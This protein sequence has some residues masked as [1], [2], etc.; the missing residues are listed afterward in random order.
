MLQ[1][2]LGSATMAPSSIVRHPPSCRYPTMRYEMLRLISLSP[3]ANQPL[4]NGVYLTRLAG[5]G[6][7]QSQ[8]GRMVCFDCGCQYGS[9][10]QV[11]CNKERYSISLLLC[12]EQM[13]EDRDALEG[14]RDAEANGILTLRGGVTV[15]G[16]ILGAAL[17]SSGPL[18][19]SDTRPVHP[20][21]CRP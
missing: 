7:F 18:D 14:V 13:S 12:L 1:V 4:P 5:D 8:G 15:T 20:R 17:P 19:L 21:Q 6:Y 10:H 3:S 9:G 16:E 2:T 11:G